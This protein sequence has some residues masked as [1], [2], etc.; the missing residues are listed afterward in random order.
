MLAR[1][2]E[3]G[4]FCHMWQILKMF[5]KALD[6]CAFGVYNGVMLLK[7]ATMRDPVDGWRYY[8]NPYDGQEIDTECAIDAPWGEY[9][10]D[11]VYETLV[12]EFTARWS[13]ISHSWIPSEI[14]GASRNVGGQ[15]VRIG[16]EFWREEEWLD[17][18]H[19]EQ[20]AWCP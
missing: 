15:W 12:V 16:K 5:E 19:D 9:S 4:H 7:G 3:F 20:E 14:N 13:D 6:K 1:R 17:E 2:T 8:D 10:N 11:E 18:L